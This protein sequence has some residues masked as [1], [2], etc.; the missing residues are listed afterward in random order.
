MA[1]TTC[2]TIADSSQLSRT[3]DDDHVWMAK[4]LCSQCVDFD[5]NSIVKA[6]TNYPWERSLIIR[7]D[8]LCPLCQ[9]FLSCVKDDCYESGSF[10][11]IL[12]LHKHIE[13]KYGWPLSIFPSDNRVRLYGAT[14]FVEDG[15]SLKI[16][17]ADVRRL[18]ADSFDIAMI[19]N[20]I[21]QCWDEHTVCQV[22][23]EGVSEPSNW[24][25][26]SSTVWRKRL[27]TPLQI[28]PMSLSVTY[29]EAL[30]TRPQAHRW[31]QWMAFHMNYEGQS[32]MR[33]M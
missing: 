26:K 16:P 21:G 19:K 20:W 33:C 32:K 2:S 4:D 24:S 10:Q 15:P 9:F 29:G 27:S 11:E 1:G 12:L 8:K 31:P 23:P 18:R 13:S 5:L 6:T 28:A 17:V 7:S 22:S 25:S 3:A 14:I 30:W